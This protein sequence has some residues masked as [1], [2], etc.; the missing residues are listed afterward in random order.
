MGT[1]IRHRAVAG[2]SLSGDELKPRLLALLASIVAAVPAFA[3]G[4]PKRGER[5]FQR[6]FAC[7]SVDAN[8]KAKLQGPNLNRVIGRRAGTLEG[9]EY[10]EGMAAWGR[11]GL[12]WSAETLDHFL[13]E[14]ETAVTGTKMAMPPLTDPQDRADIIA[15][16]TAANEGAR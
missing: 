13:T 1:R 7:H 12:V 5:Q 8:E 16:L 4:D 14:P 3:E 11:A 10:S 2:H 9:Y 6:C 15:Y